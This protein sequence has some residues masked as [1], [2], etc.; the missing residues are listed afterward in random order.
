MTGGRCTWFLRHLLQCGETA[1]IR[2]IA[3]LIFV[4]TLYVLLCRVMSPTF[5]LI[6]KFKSVA[7][8]KNDGIV[9]ACISIVSSHQQEW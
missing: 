3:N 2:D 9:R 5:E 7:G 1:R 8:N 4:A 6:F